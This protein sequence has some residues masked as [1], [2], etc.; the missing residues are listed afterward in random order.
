[1]SLGRWLD[2]LPNAAQLA[3]L[4]L[5]LLLIW[6]GSSIPSTNLPDLSLF[7]HDKLIHLLEYAGLGVAFWISGRKH[8]MP[9]LRPWCD[10]RFCVLFVG[11]VLP[12]ALWAASDEFHQLTVG[13]DCSIWD[14]MADVL[15]LCLAA[16]RLRHSD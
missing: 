9:R 16:W 3:A 5:A 14:W 1:M 7:S 2:R 4:P 13:R 11:V 8:W 15:G 12:G 6:W 10:S